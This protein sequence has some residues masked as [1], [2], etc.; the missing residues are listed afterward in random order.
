MSTGMAEKIE[1]SDCCHWHISALELNSLRNHMCE[2]NSPGCPALQGHKRHHKYQMWQNEV[3]L[4]R[5]TS[6]CLFIF[7]YI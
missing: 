7:I 3:M 5:Y 2:I 6:P 4:A 1:F